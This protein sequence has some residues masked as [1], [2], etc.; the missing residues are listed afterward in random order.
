MTAVD[1]TVHIRCIYV[2][3]GLMMS[4]YVTR[5]ARGSQGTAGQWEQCGK[6]SIETSRSD[7]LLLGGF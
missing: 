1:L 2:R 6:K 5:N 3:D 4:P 7:L